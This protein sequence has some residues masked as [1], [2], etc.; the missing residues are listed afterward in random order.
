MDNGGWTTEINE[1]PAFAGC[2]CQVSEEFSRCRFDQIVERWS[3]ADPDV[4][5][6]E[7]YTNDDLFQL[8]F[9][10]EARI[11]GSLMVQGRSENKSLQML[12]I[13]E[14]EQAV[15]QGAVGHGHFHNI[16]DELKE[17]G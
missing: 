7:C 13:F 4:H 6:E 11:R 12:K 10:K 1:K 15:I 2:E 16:I 17:E 8:S 14:E 5:N 3:S 9:M